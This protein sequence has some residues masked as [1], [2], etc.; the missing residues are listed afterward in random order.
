MLI[1]A[2]NVTENALSAANGKASV[3]YSYGVVLLE[4]ITGKKPLDASFMISWV[5]WVWKESGGE[6]ERIDDPR[7]MKEVVRSNN[8]REQSK[9]V[10]VIA[11]RCTEMIL[12]RDLQCEML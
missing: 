3:V 5:G 9:E 11:L 8:R 4:L 2:G 10:I 7:L 12:T 1:N 6:I